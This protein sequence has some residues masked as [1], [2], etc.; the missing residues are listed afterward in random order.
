VKTRD[1]LEWDTKQGDSEILLVANNEVYY[2]V[3]DEIFKA[4][5]LNGK[6]LGKAKLLIK[7]EVVPDIHWAF[8]SK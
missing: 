2:R 1:Y 5:I 7:N 8:L 6:K 4:P 3:S